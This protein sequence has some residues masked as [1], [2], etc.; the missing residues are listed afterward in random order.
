MSLKKTETASTTLRQQYASQAEKDYPLISQAEND[1]AE[2]LPYC[3]NQLLQLPLEVMFEHLQSLVKRE[4]DTFS[5]ICI[6]YASEFDDAYLAH[7]QRL[8]GTVSTKCEGI[9]RGFQGEL[10]GYLSS[11]V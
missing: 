10:R 7:A 8:Q 11:T 4:C 1:G 6:K 9:M 5:V 3:L 2:P